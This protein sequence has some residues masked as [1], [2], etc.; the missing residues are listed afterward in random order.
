MKGIDRES[1]KEKIA[2]LKAQILETEDTIEHYRNDNT[3]DDVILLQELESRR[4]ILDEQLQELK[5][6]LVDLSLSGK[7]EQTYTLS[8]NGKE[9][10]ITVVSANFT[11]PAKGF[12]S[13]NSP[14]AQALEGRRIGDEVEVDTPGGKRRYKLVK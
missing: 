7:K 10:T 5:N 3:G 9:Q 14:L 12:I 6:S 2:K 8:F 4:A 11:D 1:L 13:D